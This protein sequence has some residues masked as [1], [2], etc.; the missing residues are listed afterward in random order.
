[1]T[2]Q[3]LSTYNITDFQTNEQDENIPK[4]LLQLQLCP[5]TKGTNSSETS[6]RMQCFIRRYP[7]ERNE[8]IHFQKLL[9]TQNFTPD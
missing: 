5:V 3:T 7:H 9:P 1:M 8:L 6:A 2:L 4:I